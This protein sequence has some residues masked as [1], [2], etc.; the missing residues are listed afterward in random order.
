MNA[1]SEFLDYGPDAVLMAG[2]TARW[3]DAIGAER[4]AGQ[5]RGVAAGAD[6]TSPDE[7]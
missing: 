3:A 7:D 2:E 5:A 4:L 6:P 1:P